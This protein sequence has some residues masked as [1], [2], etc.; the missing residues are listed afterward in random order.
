MLRVYHVFRH[1]SGVLANEPVVVDADFVGV[2]P[3]GIVSGHLEGLTV[4]AKS[5]GER[6]LN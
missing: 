3:L 2:T 5:P 4:V 1:A 6:S